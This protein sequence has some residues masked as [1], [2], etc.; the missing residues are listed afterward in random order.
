M[1]TE[2]LITT[3]LPSVLL[4]GFHGL[5]PAMGWLFAVFLALQRRSTRTLLLALG[6]I[7]AGHAAS[8]AAIALIILVAR[9]TLPVM[10]VRLSTA[11]V[12]LLFGT[13]KL[14]TLSRH[15]R[16]VGLNVGYAD[17]AWWS[18]LMATAHGSGLMLAPLI[19]GA[20]GSAETVWLLVA[21]N[22]AMLAVMAA[23]ALLVY[24]KLGVMA[25]RRLWINYDL[26]WAACLVLAGAVSFTGLLIAPAH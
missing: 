3:T 13:Y 16:W 5:N 20:P 21:H 6:P 19:L 23:M 4:G 1:L 26:L 22:L 24:L 18:F 11:L 2:P 25:V 14:L 8:V 7:A 9:S 10:P 15:P 12:V 17:L